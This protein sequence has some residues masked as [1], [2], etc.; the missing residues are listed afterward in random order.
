MLAMAS[1]AQWDVDLTG[2][3]GVVDSR[4]AG[5]ANT[6]SYR[7]IMESF[8]WS[9]SPLHGFKKDSFLHKNAHYT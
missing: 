2:D 3:K 7:V 9:L 8:L 1:V 4:P 6:L 5:E